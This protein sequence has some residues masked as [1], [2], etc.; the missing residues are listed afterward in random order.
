MTHASLTTVWSRLE[1]LGSSDFMV[2]R[3]QSY[4]YADLA[5]AVRR[6]TQ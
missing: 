2:L 1:A 3:D 5:D 6:V 4:S